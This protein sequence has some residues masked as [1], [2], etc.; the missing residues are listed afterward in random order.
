VAEG[1]LRVEISYM[2]KR[3]GKADY[4]DFITLLFLQDD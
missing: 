4:F 1:Q 3:T 2:V